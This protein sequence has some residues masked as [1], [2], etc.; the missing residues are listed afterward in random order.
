MP[1]ERMI[2]ETRTDEKVQFLEIR[3]GKR[4]KMSMLRGRVCTSAPSANHITEFWRK[5]FST[6]CILTLEGRERGRGY[7]Y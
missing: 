6:A 1:I 5:S 2:P 4:I 7:G 3:N